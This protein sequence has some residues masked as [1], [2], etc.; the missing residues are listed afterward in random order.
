MRVEGNKRN[1]T[2]AHSFE[3][4]R[5]EKPPPTLCSDRVRD[6]TGVAEAIGIHRS[7]HEEVD[8]R[9]LQVPQYEGLCLYVLG[10]SHPSAA[11]RI[12]A[13]KGVKTISHRCNKSFIEADGRQ[14]IQYMHPT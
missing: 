11:Q 3:C 2:T 12:T 5:R 13:R 8:S 14:K 7:D 9:R 1:A 10:E 6:W 4:E